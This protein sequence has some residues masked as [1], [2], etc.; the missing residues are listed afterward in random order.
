MDITSQFIKLVKISSPSGKEAAMSVY[1]QTWLATHNFKFQ[2]DSV[3]NIYA[4]N[5]KQGTPLLFCAHMDTVQPGEN[6]HPVIENGVIK[7]DGRTI[8]GADNKAA[9]AAIMNAVE[10]NDDRHL[11]LLFTVKEEIGGG[12]EFFPF[13]WIKSKK[14]IIFDS[15][16]PLGGIVLRSPFIYNFD[17][18]CAGKA[19]HAS[20]PE[21]GINAFTPAFQALSSLHVGCLDKKETTINI[22]L[23]EG[24]TGMNIIPN[25]IHIQGE[26]RS[27]DKTLFESH[28]KKIQLLFE[29][30]AKKYHV[31]C[32]FSPNGYCAGYS[33]V[34]SSVFVKQIASVY[35]KVGLKT[36]YYEYSGISDANVLNEHGVQTVNLTDGTQY[37]HTTKEQITVSDLNKLSEIVKKS[38]TEL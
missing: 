5:K 29:Q 4:T 7:S 38:I 10:E 3:G 15:S 26:I 35:E 28:L 31:T 19:A 32:K 1:L 25:N 9:M 14:A 16:K 24:G 12:V 20:T 2:I 11:E 36:Q 34:K 21:V 8:I 23:I 37:P 6:I 30:E 22:G 17:I 33:F 18:Q 13:D 27:Y